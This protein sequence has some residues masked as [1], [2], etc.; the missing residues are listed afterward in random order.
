MALACCASCCECYLFALGNANASQK[1]CTNAAC[2][3]SKGYITI[4]TLHIRITSIFALGID[5]LVNYN[6]VRPLW[7]FLCLQSR[8]RHDCDANLT[9]LRDLTAGSYGWLRLVTVR[10]DVTASNVGRIESVLLRDDFI[11]R[12]FPYY[13]CQ[14]HILGNTEIFTFLFSQILIANSDV[15]AMVCMLV[16]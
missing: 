1:V 2:T 15:V 11:R 5:W 12:I 7:T 10:Q 9:L 16:Q 13:Y 3:T 6:D 8:L 14:N 4:A